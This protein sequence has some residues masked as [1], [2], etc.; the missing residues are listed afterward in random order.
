MVRA[1]K[2]KGGGGGN[3]MSFVGWA[4]VSHLAL[5]AWRSNSHANAVLAVW[6]AQSSSDLHLPGAGDGLRM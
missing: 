4:A 6:K 2:P 1:P 5:R 3:D